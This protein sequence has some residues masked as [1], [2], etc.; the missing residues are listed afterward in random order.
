MV[1]LPAAGADLQERLSVRGLHEGFTRAAL[2]PYAWTLWGD[3]G[4]LGVVS[5]A[6]MVVVHA[7]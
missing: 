6:C 4:C 7:A 2:L 1:P 5:F 3:G